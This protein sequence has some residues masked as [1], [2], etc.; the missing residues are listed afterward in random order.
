MRAG[1]AWDERF[2]SRLVGSTN[3]PEAQQLRA[4][5][6]ARRRQ[7]SDA[8]AA[9]L[10]GSLESALAQL[11]LAP[12]PSTQSQRIDASLHWFGQIG[13]VFALV[14]DRRLPVYDALV[15][16]MRELSAPHLR[17]LPPRL[18]GSISRQQRAPQPGS[19]CLQ[20]VPD[21]GSPRSICDDP[22][23]VFRSNVCWALFHG[24]FDELNAA[25]YEGDGMGARFT[26]MLTIA[27][28]RVH[29]AFAEFARE[30]SRRY[31]DDQIGDEMTAWWQTVNTQTGA[32]VADDQYKVTVSTDFGEFYGDSAE[33]AERVLGVDTLIGDNFLG[34]LESLADPMGTLGAMEQRSDGRIGMTTPWSIA[35]SEDVQEFLNLWPH[36]STG[37]VQF[38]KNLEAFLRDQPSLQE[39]AGLW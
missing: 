18:R 20:V 23:M 33:V 28:A 24:R 4:D 22:G 9:E 10:E 21:R 26:G 7:V 8:A 14:E 17:L 2:A 3:A 12:S 36:H 13:P 25:L 38:H 1:V 5:F 16:R 37:E 15:G 11:P 32:V 39:R 6:L 31:G 34:L 30:C 29:F 27:P 19:P 35:I